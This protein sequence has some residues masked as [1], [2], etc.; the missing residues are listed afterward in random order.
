VTAD[1]MLDQQTRCLLAFAGEAGDPRVAPMAYWSD[2]EAL[3][4]TTAA[5][6]SKVRRLSE[7]PA[8][9][10]CVLTESHA[11]V[12]AGQARIFGLDDPLGLA[13]HAGPVSGALLGLAIR[14]PA[15]VVAY[16]ESLAAVPE[17]WWPHRRVVL[18]IRIDEPELVPLPAV[19]AGMAPAL[20][21][22]VP[23]DVRRALAGEHRVVVAYGAGRPVVAPAVWD[24]DFRLSGPGGRSLA[25]HGPVAVALDAEPLASPLDAC[26]VVLSGDAPDGRLSARKATWWRGFDRETVDLAERPRGVV[27]P[28]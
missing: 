12:A 17:R 5:D 9:R 28:D 4:M 14:N 26:G 10:I 18:R 23:A 16:V 1:A 19:P 27:L 13:L 11:L 3:W 24:A 25:P 21:E 7:E 8:C 2:G 20:P 22:A 15:T 6:S